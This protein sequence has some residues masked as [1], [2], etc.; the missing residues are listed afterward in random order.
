LQAFATIGWKFYLVFIII[1]GLGFFVVWWWLPETKGIP[2]E[3]MAKL[4][5]DTDIAV[6][7]EDIHVDHNTHELVVEAHDGSHVQR[8]ATEGALPP[9]T[10]QIRRSIEGEKDVK[11]V[12]DEKVAAKA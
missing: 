10:P 12:Q 9:G 2:L 8:V 1:S 3:E 7:Q 5:G 4:F 6:Y 11:I